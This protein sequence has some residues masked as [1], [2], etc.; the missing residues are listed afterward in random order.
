[1]IAF[2][3]IYNV[4]LNPIIV[5]LKQDKFMSKMYLFVGISFIC[6][7]SLLTYL[8]NYKGMLFSMCIAEAL[9]L[10]YSIYLIYKQ[11]EN[12]KGI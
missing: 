11:L 5:S 1:M 7:G 6:F 2:L 10:I 8:F 12:Q 9:I 3:T 4:V